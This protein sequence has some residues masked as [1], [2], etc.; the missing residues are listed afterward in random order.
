[1]PENT[2]ADDYINILNADALL[3]D[4]KKQLEA[5]GTQIAVIMANSVNRMIELAPDI[6]KSEVSPITMVDQLATGLREGI[7]VQP[8][9]NINPN[10]QDDFLRSVTFQKLITLMGADLDSM[11]LTDLE[12]AGLSGLSKSKSTIVH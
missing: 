7:C 12:I 1:M 11:S 8:M 6:I 9:N 5:L 2:T 4:N 10:W 3:I